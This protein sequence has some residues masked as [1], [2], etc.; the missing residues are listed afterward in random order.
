MK[1]RSRGSDAVMIHG[2]GGRERGGGAGLIAAA[3]AEEE[4]RDVF[5]VERS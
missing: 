4:E 1:T 2:D 5:G 3:R